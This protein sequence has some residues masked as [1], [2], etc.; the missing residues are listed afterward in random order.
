MSFVK[1]TSPEDDVDCAP[2]P[3]DAIRPRTARDP[4]IQRENRGD[5]RRVAFMEHAPALTWTA[6]AATGVVPE[7]AAGP[8]P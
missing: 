1:V 7:N 5:A 6:G 8:I 3:A 4:D 2:T